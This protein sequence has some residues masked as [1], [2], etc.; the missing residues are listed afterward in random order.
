MGHVAYIRK[1]ANNAVFIAVNRWC[2]DAY[3]EIPQE[4]TSC[5]VFFGNQPQDNVLKI[6]KESFAILIKR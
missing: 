2:D 3:V 4:F 1:T 6:D 5:N